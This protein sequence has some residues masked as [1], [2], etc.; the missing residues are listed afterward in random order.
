VTYN[1]DPDRWYEDEY[2]ALV[3]RRDVGEYSPEAFNA[4]LDA[5]YSRYEAMVGRLDGTYRLP[6][7]AKGAFTSR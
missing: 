3:R 5:L 7:E 4:A 1:F 6:D 2:A